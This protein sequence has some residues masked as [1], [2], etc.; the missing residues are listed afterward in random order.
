MA[1]YCVRH[2]SKGGPL[3]DA[4]GI[5]WVLSVNHTPAVLPSEDHLVS[6]SIRETATALRFERLYSWTA[7]GCAI[8]G[9]FLQLASSSDLRQCRR[10]TVQGDGTQVSLEHANQRK[11]VLSQ[12]CQP[13]AI[14]G[15]QYDWRCMRPIRLAS[16]VADRCA[17]FAAPTCSDSRGERNSFQTAH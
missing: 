5:S 3:T 10:A 16:G 11:G 1:Q 13:A 15:S 17:S 6:A 14:F 7:S 4:W 12:F 8:W 9:R 2:K